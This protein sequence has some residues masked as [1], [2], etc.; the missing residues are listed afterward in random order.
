MKNQ[1]HHS[2]DPEKIYQHFL[3]RAR[4]YSEETL[5]HY[6]QRALE[7]K[8]ANDAYLA[9]MLHEAAERAAL[10]TKFARKRQRFT[11][12]DGMG[13]THL[14]IVGDARTARWTDIEDFDYS[15]NLGVIRFANG[16][17]APAVFEIDDESSGEHCGTFV[18]M[19]D[20]RVVSQR[21]KD[22][23][24]QLD[25]TK[26]DVFPYSFKLDVPIAGDIHVSDDGWRL[27]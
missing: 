1:I 9:A 23:L 13:A 11:F 15:L 4:T 20:A 21:D 14:F 24:K 25:M 7:T 26:K 22:F 6:M 12:D 19:G 16:E 27:Q 5:C 2:N 18:L 10:T 3:K 8:E 17:E